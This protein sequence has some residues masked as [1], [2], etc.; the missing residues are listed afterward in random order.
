MRTRREFLQQ[1]GV[2]AALLPFMG[3]GPEMQESLR[4]TRTAPSYTIPS[5]CGMCRYRCP[6]LVGVHQGHI[7]D[8]A[9]NPRFLKS[10]IC[11]KAQAAVKLLD[12]EDR[13]RYPMKRIG[14]RGSGKWQRIDW[15]E[16]IDTITRQI[17]QILQ[18][19]GP[20]AL[21][22]FAGG[23]SSVYVQELWADIGSANIFSSEYFCNDDQSPSL[24][25]LPDERPDCLLV[26]G[27][28][29]GEN[30]MPETLRRVLDWKAAGTKLVVVDPRYSVLADKADI[31]LMIRPGTDVALLLGFLN[32]LHNKG[33]LQ[34]DEHL[35]SQ[36][37]AFDSGRVA[38]L[39]DLTEESIEQTFALMHRATPNCLAVSG[40]FR[41]WYGNDT[42]RLKGIIAIN[43]FFGHHSSQLAAEPF[44]SSVDPQ[45]LLATSSKGALIGCW[46]QNI[47]HS[48]PNPYRTINAL[49]EAAFVFCT[50]VMP[51]ETAMYADI[52]LP[53]AT[54]LE[55]TD[56]PRFRKN[57]RE[58]IT[59]LGFPIVDPA[60]E[61]KGPYW[62]VRQLSTRLGIGKN[63]THSTVYERIDHDLA[64][65][66]L[67]CSTLFSSQG[68]VIT[69]ESPEKPESPPLVDDISLPAFV[70]LSV[71][72]PGFARLISGR[73]PAHSNSSTQNNQWLSREYSS[74]EL[75][76]NDKTAAMMQLLDGEKVYLENQ[77]GLRSFFPV[78]LKITAG[79]RVDCVYMVH[80]FGCFSSRQHRAFGRGVGDSFLL[81]R[82]RKD[83]VT[84]QG[85]LRNNFVRLL[86]NGKILDIPML[87][88]P[89]VELS[90]RQ[91]SNAKG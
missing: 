82:S 8:I 79:I 22:L 87:D 37:Q 4:L 85:G 16:A 35:I 19:Q 50:D 32:I 65:R 28:H 57:G 29:L 59:M 49:M 44:K 42:E 23:S 74:N 45:K 56:A 46:G 47:L 72:P 18:K 33:G 21:L 51:S 10:G 41:N 54:F 14:E 15:H 78:R 66:H 39:T 27:G 25:S 80:G 7:V 38:A 48:Q 86:K 61:S 68:I 26:L 76:I 70:A 64:E 1:S 58:R 77:D 71:P 53:E 13:L 40:M 81:S 5:L 73:H 31:H 88:R 11:A 43:T 17:Q 24:L 63:F 6:L 52:I 12:D 9:V 90:A 60:Y 2:A 89:P 30:F 84:G 20:Q 69:E 3:S 91:D 75:W 34:G 36:L 67:S 62:I 55:R 83:P